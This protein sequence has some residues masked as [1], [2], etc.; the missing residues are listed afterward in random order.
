[1]THAHFLQR[2]PRPTFLVGTAAQTRA[3]ILPSAMLP[4]RKGAKPAS[5]E[6]RQ[7][8]SCEGLT[9]G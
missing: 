4:C 9:G 5:M 1:M 3:G 2:S 8:V 7:T 6:G